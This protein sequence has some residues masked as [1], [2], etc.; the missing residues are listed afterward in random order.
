MPGLPHPHDPAAREDHEQHG[1]R[2][3]GQQP[4]VQWAQWDEA[5][6]IAYGLPQPLPN[7]L[8]PLAQC[9]DE[10]LAEAV[11]AE[12]PVP[13]YA[14]AAADGWAV[15]GD[16]PWRIRVPQPTETDERLLLTL[17]P[18]KR[19][20]P[21]VE[22]TAGEATHVNTGDAVP[23]GTTAV[24]EAH[25]GHVVPADPTAQIPEDTEHGRKPEEG[26]TLEDATPAAPLVKNQDVRAVGEE[27]EQGDLLLRAGRKLNPVHLGLAASAGH[28]M[29]PVRRRPRVTVLLG[30]ANVVEDGIPGPGEVR[31]SLSLQLPA[32]LH[33]LGANVDQVRRVADGAQ[34]TVSALTESP[35]GANSLLDAR[36]E[37][38]VT[39][40]G[41]GHGEDDHVR[42]ALEELD[43]HLIIDGVAQE[44]AHGVILA[45]LP[46]DGPVVLAL[47]GS[48]LS[49]ITG[50]LTVGHALIAGAT[51]EG[52]PVTRRIT[53]GQGLDPAGV[54]R[55][56][57]AYLQDGRV[58]PE[59]A[60]GPAMLSG[61]A[62]ADVLLV[63]PEDGMKPGQD[64]E[65]VPLPW[66]V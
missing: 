25:R 56:I 21:V 26:D 58:V 12:M 5:R 2:Q 42:Q 66:R 7:I 50:L 16:G 23:F 63:V 35:M 10:V 43:A 38:V 8:L 17:P 57:P 53:A 39:T 13:H 48:P 36:A 3:D 54:T 52:M 9:Q 37:I 51:G 18:E 6:R 32:V 11:T 28:D 14:S 24:L 34:G 55:I 4:T 40:G 65:V 31:D 60:T 29:L 59:P 1:T 19:M 15:A 62:H 46:E 47:P 27:I 44:P 61:L 20:L 41:T 49:A 33:E 64:M 45:K 22:L 30:F